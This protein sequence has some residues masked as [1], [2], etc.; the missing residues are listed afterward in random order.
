MSTDADYQSFPTAP[1]R[2]A[3]V[4]FNGSGFG[5]LGW[6]LVV[7]LASVVVVPVGWAAA[8][9]YRWLFTKLRLSDGTTATF[10]GRGEDIWGWFALN[11]V[12]GLLPQT[13]R[14][15]SDKREQM[16]VT[17][18]I[19][20]LGIPIA[21]YV[22]VIIARWAI[23]SIRSTR[24]KRLT[25][26]GTWGSYLGWTLLIYVS[27]LT[28]VGW[29]WATVAMINWLCR[30][31]DAEGDEIVFTGTGPQVLWR[32]VVGS[33]ACCLIIPIPWIAAWWY[34]WF[35]GCLVVRYA[36]TPAVTT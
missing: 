26:T 4:E 16:I 29:A 7:A 17:N 13:G 23:S 1:A 8:G 11:A 36:P 19:S 31:I 20:L 6:C 27:V 25:F 21:C 2:D 3:T 22:G 30:N 10:V 15:I 32:I 34:K 18:L 24:G 5:L 14:L 33:F 12:V 35:F 28:I 9:L